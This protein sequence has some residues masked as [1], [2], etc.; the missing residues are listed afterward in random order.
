MKLS[1]HRALSEL[2]MLDKRIAG[3]IN[4]EKFVTFQTGS[5]KPRGYNSKEQFEELAKSGYQSANDLIKRRNEIKSK[6]ILVNATTEVKIAGVVMTIA[7][8]IDQKDAIHYKQSL[9]HELNRQLAVVNQE[10]ERERREMEIRLDQRLNSDFG[11]DRKNFADEVEKTTAD[12][13][14]RNEP[15]M[16]DP[17]SI[18]EEIKKLEEEINSFLVEVDA[19]LSEVNATTFIELD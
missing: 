13:K 2:K 17:I 15:N 7:E 16:V 19:C 12:F 18:R 10:I 9:L 11:K 4:G 1:L 14:K 8:A 6:L 3:A 5:E